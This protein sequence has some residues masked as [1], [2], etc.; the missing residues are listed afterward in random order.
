MGPPE[1]GALVDGKHLHRVAAAVIAAGLLAAACGAPSYTYAVDA[2][3][4]VYFKVPPNW[5]PIDQQVLAQAEA[6][7][8]SHSLAGPAGGSFLWSR[9]YDASAP[10]SVGHI[11]AP[12]AEPVVYASV[13]DMSP[14]LR[15]DLSFN[16]MRDLLLP[17]TTAARKR[18]AAAHAALPGFQSVVDQVIIGSG[19][20]RGINE[21]FKY[22]LGGLPEIFDETVLTNSPTTR[23]YLLL[24]QCDSTCFVAHKGQIAAVVGSFTVRGS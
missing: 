7:L 9:A 19:G 3:D 22:D 18:A 24:I 21:I 8:L 2:H 15:A 4:Q 12:T 17:V 16:V 10:P 23:L 1:Q 6:T 13:Q 14:Q 5:R 11:F 20:I